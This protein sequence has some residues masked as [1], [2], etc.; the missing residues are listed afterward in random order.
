MQSLAGCSYWPLTVCSAWLGTGE[1]LA[2]DELG[3]RCTLLSL[4]NVRDTT[5]VTEILGL[6]ERA[7]QKLDLRNPNPAFSALKLFQFGKMLRLSMP[8]FPQMELEIIPAATHS[9]L[10]ILYIYQF[11]SDKVLVCG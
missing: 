11:P 7:G 6:Q 8:Q 10:E 1:I 5:A 2:M 3:L 9:V 4:R